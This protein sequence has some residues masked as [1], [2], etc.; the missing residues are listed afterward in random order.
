MIG[1]DAACELA[2]V[3][4]ETMEQLLHNQ[5]DGFPF[6]RSIKFVKAFPGDLHPTEVISWGDDQQNDL[7]K[8]KER[9]R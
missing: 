2:G 6:P 8:W 9:Q 3:D 1:F 7:R 4:A 5:P